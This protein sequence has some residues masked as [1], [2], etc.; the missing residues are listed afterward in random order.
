MKVYLNQI[1][2]IADAIVSLHMSKRT[3]TREKELEIRHICNEV[4][5]IDGMVNKEHLMYPQFTELVEKIVRFGPQHIT[6]LRY[7]DFSFTIEGMHRGAQDDFDSH[8][9]RLEN[10]I[11][12]SSTRLATFGNEMSDYYKNKIITT[13]GVIA[14]LNQIQMPE[15]IYLDNA[16]KII[17]E[18]SITEEMI[19]NQVAH[20]FVKAINGYIREDLKDDNDVK[21]GLYM[22]SIPSN[23]IFKINCTEFAHVLKMRDKNS[24]A[25][26]ELQ[27]GVEGMLKA[28]NNQYEWFT[29]EFF[30]SIQN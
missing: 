11:I 15:R 22:L 18:E 4:C 29:R 6:L 12:R 17:P 14:Q 16:G 9:K 25:H 21:R 10:R 27:I 13:D 2:G 20:S 30:Y 5:D 8:A 28:I 24:H 23:F 26:P 1:E 3:W 19:Q 7:I